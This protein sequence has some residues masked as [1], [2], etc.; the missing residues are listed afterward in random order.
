LEFGARVAIPRAESSMTPHEWELVG[1]IYHAACDVQPEKLSEFLD[2]ACEG[3]GALRREVESLLSA[4][5]QAENFIS[6]PI[7][8]NLAKDLLHSNSP[9]END[10]IGHY[11]VISKIG[12]GGMGEV[13]HA[14]D[15]KL[16]RN[17]AVKM[18]S[19]FYDKDPSFL[20][21]F[22][23]EAR[24]AATLNH[25][26]VATVYSVEEVSEQSFITMEL[27]S[28]STL[29]QIT[30]DN[31]LE[32][33]RFLEWFE[34]L[35]DALAQ[36]H[37]R[38]IIHRDVKPGNIMVSE[39]GTPKILD[40]GLAQIENHDNSRSLSRAHITAPG[41]IIGTPSYMSPEQAEGSKLDARSDIFSFGVVMYEALTGKRP[42]RGENQGAIVQAVIYAQP[43][44]ISKLR[45]DVPEL[46]SKMVMRCL[47][48][49]P[50]K[51][52]QSMKDV[53][54]I[55]RDA[56]SAVSAGVSMDSFA[57][58]FYLEAT[59]PSKAWWLAA[60]ALVLILSFGGWFF[61]SRPASGPPINFENMAMRRLSENNNVGYA[62]ISADGKM[63]LYGSFEPDGNLALWIRRVEDRNALLLISE[64]KSL[65]GGLALSPDGGQAFYITAE[66]TGT[67][68]TLYRISTIGGPSRKLVDV[69]NDVG[70]ISPDGERI[71]LVRYG[72]P[73]Q[74]ISVKTSDG[75]GEQA[76][77]SGIS[78]GLTY[79]N[80]RDP[81]YS[82]DGQAIYFIRNLTTEGVEDWSVEE[83]R[84]DTGKTRVLYR[85][86]ERIS[87]LAVLPG[88]TG[89]LMTAVDPVS[90]LQ[91]IF[92]ISTADG[93]KS[94]VTNDLFFYFGVS[95]DR[96]AK[97]V[98]ASQRADEQRVWVGES[99]NLSGLKPLGQ[100]PN[101]N[102]SVDWTPNGR[103][104]YDAYDNN[105]SHIWISDAD[106]R[107]VQKLTADEADDVDPHV[108]GDG[109]Y[110][111]FSSKR[112]GRG[113]VWR[114]DV[115]G[116][117]QIL[118][119]DF[120][121]VSGYP[122]FAADGQ[123][124]VFEWL[125]DKKRILAS[126]PVSG[127]QVTEIRQLDD[128]P[129]SNGFYWAPS[130]DGRYL[131][132]SIW[133][134]SSKQMKIALDPLFPNGERRILDIW[135]SAILKWS[136]DGRNIIYRERR[137]GYFP[138]GEIQKLDISSG[139]TT[140]LVSAA[141]P[142]LFIGLSFSRDGKKVALVRGKNTSNAVMLIPASPK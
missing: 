50:Q 81:Q 100:E 75:S 118:L 138:E 86:P 111:V 109:R 99:S 131:A 37:R 9:S 82:H 51:R 110:I 39:D 79:S 135:P 96:E 84:L 122:K 14:V 21:R 126:I 72:E 101:V 53:R 45:P 5:G 23:N 117:H 119:T 133:E 13:F 104:V 78:Q 38:G 44:E 80:F 127:G 113:Q 11:R 54:S 33:N 7:A 26:N 136:P 34:P 65:W 106:G 140:K 29:D 107:N 94:R 20:K 70:G 125:Y 30:P 88:S 76:I 57:R 19:S 132:Q 59:T 22:R 67:H 40:F 63:V 141:L 4:R 134:P 48:K 12:S 10:M 89:L 139:K 64:R 108:S 105:V 116:S 68:G 17:V 42:F 28:G 18:L 112:S 60:A 41:Q 121:G 128:I 93:S 24:A 56:K 115:D 142:E 2:V 27:V 73:A 62:Q 95:I 61:L 69:A 32:V 137:P 92:Q 8:G 129:R 97:Y 15:T 35:A 1:E 31:G 103:I 74:I 124:V 43:E 52:F 55:L 3:D 77:L 16:D 85:Q 83:M 91:Q 46:L 102:R 87:E 123:T 25:P 36:A 6:D 47:E 49:S 90:N 114:M 130:P 98:V 120:N 71:L 66:L 58:R